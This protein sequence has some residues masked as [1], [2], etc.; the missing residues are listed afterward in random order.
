MILATIHVPPEY[1]GAV[2]GL[3]QERRGTQRDMHHHGSRVQVRYELPLSEVVLDFHDRIKS[4]TRGYG[5]FDYELVG[6]RPASLVKLDVLVNGDP[7][8]RALADRAPRQ[9]LP[10]RHG[11]GAQAQGV[12]PAPDVRGGDPGGDRLG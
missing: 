1:V 6:Y 2:L 4:V 9:G 11:A 7:G 12:H 5:S 10:P 3:C 8:R